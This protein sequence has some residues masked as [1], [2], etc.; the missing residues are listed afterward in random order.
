[1]DL[2]KKQFLMPPCPLTNLEIQKCYQN[3]PRFNWI[4]SKDNLPLK[5]R[6][7]IYEINLYEYADI[8]THWIALCAL[9][10]DITYFDSFG[11][12]HISK[13][14]KRSIGNKNMQTNIFR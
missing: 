4:Y 12:E 1:M 8:G 10:N 14:I 11:V 13:E 9:N 3:K 2:L 7:G 6:D 5:I